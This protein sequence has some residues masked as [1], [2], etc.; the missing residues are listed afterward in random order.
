MNK[1]AVIAG[2]ML[3][4]LAALATARAEEGMWTFDNL[5]LKEMQDHYQFAPGAD[6][7]ANVE[8]AALRLKGGCSASFV[9]ADGLVL[10]NRHCVDECLAELSTP[11]KDYID[12]GY[13]AR[14]GEQ[15][16]RCP[17][18]EADE[19][20]ASADVTDQV[21]AKLKDLSGDAYAEAF[22]SVSARLEQDCADGDTRRWNCQLV[23]LYHGGRYALYKY[24]RYQDLRLVFA[25][26][27][28]IADFGGD[29]DNFNFPRY[30]L[31]AALLRAY[32]RD[33]P[34]QG[35]YLRFAS[36]GPADGELVFTA[37]N[38]GATERG[39]TVAELKTLRDDDIMPTL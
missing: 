26:E 3:A 37:G 17:D 11:T 1:L 23:D 7:L 22:A 38:P 30:C 39:W 28:A 25:P 33:Q 5:P 15:E 21:A 8:H 24:R 20:E 16:L 29:P 19:L 14:S 13:Y 35:P 34:V 27:S 32:D 2:L 4:C 6:W 31:D 36:S 12:D 9:S 18:V 10:T